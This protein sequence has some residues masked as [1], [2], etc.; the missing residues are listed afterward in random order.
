[1]GIVITTHTVGGKQPNTWGLSDTRG[2]VWEW[3]SDVYNE[4]LFADSVPGQAG[5]A[6]VLKEDS[7]ES[8]VKHTTWSTHAGGPGSGFDV[9]FR[10]VQEVR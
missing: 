1:M 10:I 5:S 4:K 7:F 8:D 6:H 3:V 2:N 9:G